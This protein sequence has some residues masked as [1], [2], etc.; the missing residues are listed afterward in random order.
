[1]AMPSIQYILYMLKDDSTCR[2]TS[3]QLCLQGTAKQHSDANNLNV[4]TQKKRLQP[5]CRLILQLS[6]WKS[7]FLDLQERGKE[8]KNKTGKDPWR[9]LACLCKSIHLK[10]ILFQVSRVVS[11]RRLQ[12]IGPLRRSSQRGNLGFKVQIHVGAG[13]TAAT[14]SALSGSVAVGSSEFMLIPPLILQAAFSQFFLFCFFCCLIG[15]W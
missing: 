3:W 9:Y 14:L 5:E 1:M 8:K 12:A 13:F 2:W 10:L 7:A 15:C 6:L 11:R 4:M